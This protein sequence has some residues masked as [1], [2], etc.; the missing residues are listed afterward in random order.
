MNVKNPRG[1]TSQKSLLSFPPLYWQMVWIDLHLQTAY[2]PLMS[3]SR[4]KSRA[5]E[6]HNEIKM[7]RSVFGYYANLPFL[8]SDI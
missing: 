3:L 6:A 4:K 2:K 8:W 5:M 7:L 1:Q